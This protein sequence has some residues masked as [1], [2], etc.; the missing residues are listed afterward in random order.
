MTLKTISELEHEARRSSASQ[1]LEQWGPAALVLRPPADRLERAALS[2]GG[3][4]TQA[5]GGVGTLDEILVMLRAFC[6]LQVFPLTPR[7]RACIEVGRGLDQTVI[8]TDP[9]VSK[10]HATLFLNADRG[11]E[12]IDEGS[13]NGTSVNGAVV[14]HR[15]LLSD[16]DV[17]GL[18]DVALV[19]LEASSL[20]A[21]LLSLPR[22][23]RA[24]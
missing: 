10:H 3:R 13:L 19:F 14:T 2:L 17:I 22:R 21:Q 15:F 8:L 9:S 12:I 20:H 1:W 4:S 18:G 23:E 6:E 5:Q 16:G 7:V 24:R 11:W